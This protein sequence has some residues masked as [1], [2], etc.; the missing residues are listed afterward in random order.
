M[1]LYIG[2]IYTARSLQSKI[3]QKEATEGGRG[4]GGADPVGI[5][6]FPRRSPMPVL[7]TLLCLT[8][9]WWLL[10][11]PLAAACWVPQCTVNPFAARAQLC[12]LLS[13]SGPDQE[14]GGAR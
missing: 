2:Q 7:T 12:L 3:W 5:T 8:S 10:C 9:A 6:G 4:D 14:L 1:L 11:V 13:Y